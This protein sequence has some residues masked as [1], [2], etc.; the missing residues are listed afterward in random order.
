MNYDISWLAN[1][2]EKTNFFL[3]QISEDNFNSIRYSFSGDLFD[4]KKSGLANYVFAAKILYVI[5][6]I[7]NDIIN[8]NIKKNILRFSHPDGSISDNFITELSLRDKIKIL[9]NKYDLNKLLY[10]NDII[11]AETR[12]AFASLKLLNSNPEYIYEDVPKNKEELL[13]FLQTYD[14]GNPWHAG[15]H[16]SHLLFF[17]TYNS[18]FFNFMEEE[19]DLLIK[20]SIDYI[21]KLQSKDDGCWY[22]GNPTI[23]IKINGALKIF[24]GLHSAAIYEVSYP[25][26]IIDTALLSINDNEACSNFNIAYV[27]YSASLINPNYRRHEIED[28]LFDRLNIYKRY[29]HTEYGGFSFHVNK[30]NDI[31]YGKR[32]TEGRNEPDIHGTNMFLQGIAVID[33]TLKLG[34]G[35]EIP[36]N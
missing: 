24:T 6:N 29:Y 27:L 12:Q 36:L 10:N 28:F 4:Y 16:F 19:K 15:S 5:N 22:K 23:T 2:K 11:R 26:K 3:S 8:N 18:F 34:L 20:E 7:E 32:I 14:W 30:A 35:L 21:N 17:L 31:Y 33:K 1:I 9:F 13:N 25:E